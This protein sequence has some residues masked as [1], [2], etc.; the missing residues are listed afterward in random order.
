MSCTRAV[1]WQFSNHVENPT[2][3]YLEFPLAKTSHTSAQLQLININSMDITN[4]FDTDPEQPV[5][6]EYVDQCMNDV[7]DYHYE[8]DTPF[9]DYIKQCLYIV[10]NHTVALKQHDFN[11]L[12]PNFAF[13]M[14]ECLKNTLKHTTQYARGDTRIPMRKHFHTQFPAA[15]VPHWND[16]VA[17]DTKFSNVPA[18]D[19]GDVTLQS[20]CKLKIDYDTYLR[21]PLWQWMSFNCTVRCVPQKSFEFVIVKEYQWSWQNRNDVDWTEMIVTD[22]Q[23]ILSKELLLCHRKYGSMT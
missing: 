22:R 11:R 18:H 13:P 9:E 2:K 4:H 5:F 10:H 17:M 23:W 1:L 8:Y 20:R 21:L 7:C 15:N 19:D 14:T 16:D 3:V 12:K 6:K